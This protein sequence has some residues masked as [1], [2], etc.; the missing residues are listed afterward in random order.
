M[1]HYHGRVLIIVRLT[2]AKC[3]AKAGCRLL[4]LPCGTGWCRLLALPTWRQRDLS[5]SM[6][7]ALMLFVGCR[8]ASRGGWVA[9][10]CLVD[11]GCRC[12]L[13][14]TCRPCWGSFLQ[15]IFDSCCCRHSCCQWSI[16]L[17]VIG[18]RSCLQLPI[19]QFYR[20]SRLCCF[21][22]PLGPFPRRVQDPRDRWVDFLLGFLHWILWLFAY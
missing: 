10:R 15:K 9:D 19:S 3:D 8:L 16:S 22:Q 7:P 2:A 18:Y 1:A 4:L 5:A 12:S 14:K 21:D 13:A 20:F 11:S 17:L 6:V